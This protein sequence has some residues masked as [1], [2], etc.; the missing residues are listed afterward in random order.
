MVYKEQ[1]YEFSANN[2]TQLQNYTFPERNM[3]DAELLLKILDAWL[4]KWPTDPTWNK[5]ADHENQNRHA[6]G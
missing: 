5:Y 6:L 2:Y 3:A 4:L 1:Y